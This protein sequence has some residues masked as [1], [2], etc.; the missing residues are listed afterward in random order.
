MG[1][2]HLK[3]IGWSSPAWRVKR[4]DSS[5]LGRDGTSKCPSRD[6]HLHVKGGRR[7][8]RNQRS[9]ASDIEGL[10][11]ELDAIEDCHCGASGE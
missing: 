8:L 4:G 9:W 10:L 11:D 5:F 6:W 1:R 2:V 7:G 3:G